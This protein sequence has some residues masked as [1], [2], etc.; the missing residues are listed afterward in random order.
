MN[1]NRKAELTASDRREPSDGREARGDATR[2]RLI[3]AAARIFDEHGY[4]AVS[5]R[6]IARQAGV[7]QAAILYHFKSKEGLYQAVAEHLAFTASETLLAGYRD[8]KHDLP[9]KEAQQVLE[10]LLIKM[11]QLITSSRNPFPVNLVVHEQTRPGPGFDVLYS[12]YI[13]SMHEIVSRLLATATN[14]D[15]GDTG[16]TVDAHALI[17]M[18]LGFAVARETFLRRVGRRTYSNELLA[19][20]Q[21]RVRAIVRSIAVPVAKTRTSDRPAEGLTRRKKA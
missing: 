3:V 13:K 18:I 20:T 6:E 10:D 7:N 19:M 17:G 1:V 15:F 12:N 21:D 5:T 4:A 9:P 2:E 11:L 14:R 8:I 16:V